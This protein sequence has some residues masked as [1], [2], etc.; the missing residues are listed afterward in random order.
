[1]LDRPD[2]GT[3]TTRPGWARLGFRP[4]LVL[5]MFG[6]RRSGN[7]AIADWILRNVPGE[8]SVFLNNCAPGKSPLRGFRMIEVNRALVSARAA[9]GDLAGTCAPAAPQGALLFSYEDTLPDATRRGQPVSGHFD[10]NAIAADVIAYRGF[11]N[12]AASLLRKL[13]D[14]PG[15]SASR[16]A[17][18]L[19]RAIDSY[20]GML[21]RVEDNPRLVGICYDHWLSSE[22]YRA[23][24]LHRLGLPAR[25]NSLGAVQRYGGGSSF[26]KDAATAQD[27]DTA[28]RAG[29][30]ADDPEF[31]AILDIA[32]RDTALTDILSRT[33]PADAEALAKRR[34]P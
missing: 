14:N 17:S 25:D 13:Q 16:R 5:R 27:L 7:H 15:Y 24:R 21:T 18:V 19:L 33:F 29:Q 8:G 34:A 9:H 6:M 23:E 3:P 26:Q 12:W 4:A 11:L 28:H 32:S 31:A 22:T 20:G 30:M 10:D 1:M 2:H